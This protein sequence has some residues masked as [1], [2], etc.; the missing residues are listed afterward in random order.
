MP[1]GRGS[2]SGFGSAL[3]LFVLTQKLLAAMYQLLKTNQIV[4][5]ETSRSPCR[6]EK[7]LGGGGQGEVYRADLGGRAVAVKWYF[8]RSATPQQRW[9]L[10]DL[11]RRPAPTSCFLWPI[12][13]VSDAKTPGFG[14]V[15]GLRESRYKGIVDLMKRRIEPSF[16]A[17]IT[18]GIQLADSYFQ[19]HSAGLCYRDIS[20]GNVFFDPNSGDVLICDNDNVTINGG[21]Q[22]GVLGTPKFMAPEVVRGEAVPSRD[23]DLYSLAV[24]LFYMLMVHHPLEGQRELQVKCMDLPAMNR[25][26]GTDPVFIFDPKNDTNRPDPKFHRNAIE[27]WS[28]YPETVRELFTRS[29][30]A[31]L[32]NPQQGRVKETEWRS[33]ML[34]LRDLI[35]Y[36]QHC[37]VENFFDAHFDDVDGSGQ[38]CWACRDVLRWPFRLRIDK[39]YLVMLNHDTTLYP[40]HLDSTLNHDH[41]K[42]VATISRHPT[43]PDTWGLKNLSSTKWVVTNS[44]GMLTDIPPGKNVRLDRGI[45][46]RFGST[47]GEIS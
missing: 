40:H 24:L 18:A 12:E 9:L 22:S 3:L 11:V 42:P 28:V 38:S 20:F 6:I 29:F 45:T 41:S 8:R 31:G 14:Y 4:V 30:T 16:R 32:R 23:T 5:T 44:M 1:L 35:A 34:Q 43:E 15:M 33:T 46:I 25:L 2:G 10:E 36:C 13:M 27:Y 26:Y 21:E 47:T 17:L 37:Q 19:L 39:R 7:F